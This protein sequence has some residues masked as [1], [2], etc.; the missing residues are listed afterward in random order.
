MI[1]VAIGQTDYTTLVRISDSSG[2]PITG[3]DESDIDLA[4]VRVEDHNDVV[5]AD[6]SPASL[7]ALTD[8]HTDWGFKEVSSTDH[9]GVYRLDIADAVFASGARLAVVTIVDAGT[10]DIVPVSRDF[11]LVPVDPK[12]G[13]NVDTIGGVT[14]SPDTDISDDIAAVKTVTDAIGSTVDGVAPSKILEMVLAM[15]AGK[16]AITDNAS[17][18]TMTFYKRDSSTTSFAVT[19][20]ETDGSRGTAGS[21]S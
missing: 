17:P 15:L 21:L 5:S 8:A 3:L 18:W 4:Y 2:S 10:N 11:L 16:V 13:V 7:S 19:G 1:S 9:P 14:V 6:V 20:S 12:T